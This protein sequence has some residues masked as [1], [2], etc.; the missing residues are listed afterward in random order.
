MMTSLLP[1]STKTITTKDSKMTPIAVLTAYLLG[2]AGFCYAFDGIA[3][4]LN[5]YGRR[6]ARYKNSITT[7]K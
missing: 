7:Q 1:P 5:H 6:Y 4:I 3:A 2:L